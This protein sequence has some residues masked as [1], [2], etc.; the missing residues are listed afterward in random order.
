MKP[1]I[2]FLLANGFIKAYKNEYINL[3]CSVKIKPGRF[4]IGDSKGE[5]HTKDLNIYY[6]IG[7]L[8]YHGYIKK[9]YKQ[10][11]QKENEK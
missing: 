1:I 9:D 8:T 7:F 4:I 3:I 2:D 6:L 10:L 5:T 11:N